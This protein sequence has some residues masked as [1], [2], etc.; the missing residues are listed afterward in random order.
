MR[1][2]IATGVGF[3]TLLE[4]GL[5]YFLWTMCWSVLHLE[6]CTEMSPSEEHHSTWWSPSCALLKIF[7]SGWHFG[8]V[9]ESCFSSSQLPQGTAC[10]GFHC[11][12]VFV[13]A[14]LKENNPG[15]SFSF[16]LST[17]WEEK[18]VVRSTDQEGKAIDVFQFEWVSRS[19]IRT[20]N[21]LLCYVNSIYFEGTFLWIHYNETHAKFFT[22]KREYNSA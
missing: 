5:L 7:R 20:L 12:I 8:F 15:D 1:V 16:P 22:S 3:L 10:Q 21:A 2:W 18:W 6:V 4:S 13:T 17:P 14:K 19:W 11:F 9:S